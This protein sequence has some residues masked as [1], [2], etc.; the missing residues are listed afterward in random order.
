MRCNGC[1]NEHN[2]EVCPVC[3]RD[4]RSDSRVT[5]LSRSEKDDFDGITIDQG[6]D[7]GHSDDSRQQ[8]TR[9]E[10]GR[11]YVRQVNLGGGGILSTLLIIAVFL[12]IL[13]VALPLAILLM[14]I[15]TLFWFFRRR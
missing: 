9:P 5:V 4:T 14:L 10:F 6:D 7:A 15:G 12:F 3:G 8:H 13:I 11:V 1:G 2:E